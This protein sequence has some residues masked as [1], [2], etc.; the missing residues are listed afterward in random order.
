VGRAARGEGVQTMKIGHLRA[1]KVDLLMIM[2]FVDGIE[3]S[4]RQEAV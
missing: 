2:V 3:G 4:E 1:K